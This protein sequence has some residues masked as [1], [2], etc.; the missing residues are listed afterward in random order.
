MQRRFLVAGAIFGLL[1]VIIG[2]FAT[3]GLRPLLEEASMTSFETGVKYQMYHALLLLVLGGGSLKLPKYGNAV[4]Y[5]ILFGILLF[6]GSIYLLA[7]NS[8]TSPDFTKIAL[9]TPLGGSLLIIGWVI[10]LLG[11][12]KLKKK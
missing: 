9:L 1:A 11:F 3:H 6:S 10:L 7:T 12:I 2:A 8:L 4:F 5:L